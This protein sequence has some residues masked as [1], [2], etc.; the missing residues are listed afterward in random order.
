MHWSIQRLRASYRSSEA[1]THRCPVT[2]A[3]V[4]WQQVGRGVNIGGNRKPGC[5]R[6]AKNRP[7]PRPMH[8]PST[9]LWRGCCIRCRERATTRSSIRAFAR[10]ASAHDEP[11][12]SDVVLGIIDGSIG[13]TDNEP[14]AP[15]THEQ[16]MSVVI[17]MFEHEYNDVWTEQFS[18]LEEWLV[19]N[20]AELEA[21]K[22]NSTR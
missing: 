9:R 11:L 1:K 12:S 5:E 14:R 4:T 10:P 20:D 16:K 22:N 15:G 17:M 18:A 8:A 7:F 21:T 19:T 2:S 3:G 13:G 6:A